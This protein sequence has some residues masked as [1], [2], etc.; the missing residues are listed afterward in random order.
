MLILSYENHS[1]L[2]L[3][4]CRSM[5]LRLIRS[6]SKSALRLEEVLGHRSDEEE[7]QD[8]GGGDHVVVH[9][10]ASATVRLRGQLLIEKFKDEMIPR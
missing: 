2:K 7:D 8:G 3:F 6:I 1:H 10:K 9:D 4:Y 5:M